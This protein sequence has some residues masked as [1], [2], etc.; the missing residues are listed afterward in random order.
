MGPRRDVLVLF[1]SA[2]KILQ[3]NSLIRKVL[4]GVFVGG[5][6]AV[7]LLLLFNISVPLC[8]SPCLQALKATV[9]LCGHGQITFCSGSLSINGHNNTDFLYKVL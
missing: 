1:P 5:S 8:M 2:W 6:F 3:G 9:Q 7:L 4:L